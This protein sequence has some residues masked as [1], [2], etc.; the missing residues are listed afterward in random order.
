MDNKKPNYYLCSFLLV[1]A[2]I[3]YAAVISYLYY[4]TFIYTIMITNCLTMHTYTH[5]IRN[6][7]KLNFFKPARAEEEDVIKLGI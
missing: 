5:G 7:L 2:F 3:R 4:F 1:Y 6:V